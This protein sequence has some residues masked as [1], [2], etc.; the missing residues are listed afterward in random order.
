MEVVQ[1][2]ESRI[3]IL[4]MLVGSLVFVAIYALLP[5]PDHQLPRWGGWFFGLCAAVF[6]VLL[7]RPRKLTLNDSGFSISGG[8]ARKKMVEWGDV[9]GFF[10]L[11]FRPGA[12]MIGFNY[13]PDARISRVEHGSRSGLRALMAA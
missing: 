4:L 1:I 5:D 12:N 9:T 10:P 7:L 6:L 2:V 11:S 13:S 3:K 8:L